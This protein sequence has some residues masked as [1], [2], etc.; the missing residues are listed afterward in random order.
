MV[1]RQSVS[2]SAAAAAAAV[3]VAVVVIV[4]R[5]SGVQFREKLR[6]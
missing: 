1:V 4:T 5:L 3:V 2:V 6:E